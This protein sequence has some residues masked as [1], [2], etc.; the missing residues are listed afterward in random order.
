MKD[1]THYSYQ[2]GIYEHEFRYQVV[3]YEYLWTAMQR[4][5][6]KEKIFCWNALYLIES[7]SKIGCAIVFNQ[8]QSNLVTNVFI[9]ERKKLCIVGAQ[10]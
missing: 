9:E 1:P 4:Q 3:E 5:W 8:Q 10:S 7:W 2:A 6:H